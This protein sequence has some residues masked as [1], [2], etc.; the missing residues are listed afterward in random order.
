MISTAIPTRKQ[1]QPAPQNYKATEIGRVLNV[2]SSVAVI[3]ISKKLI[4]DNQ[5]NSAQIGTILKILT[6]KSIV[7]AMVSSLKVGTNDE[8][9]MSDGCVANLNIL[10]LS[11][12]HI[13]EP[14][15]PY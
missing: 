8:E 10:G 4:R 6:T 5:L 15:R 12:I 3:Q 9:G 13:S 11:L 1:V 7:V 2:G 14:T